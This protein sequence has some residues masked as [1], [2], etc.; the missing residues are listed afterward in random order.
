MKNMQTQADKDKK[1]ELQVQITR[2][3]T[4]TQALNT[5]LRAWKEY[6]EGTISFDEMVQIKNHTLNDASDTVKKRVILNL[7]SLGFMSK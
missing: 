1:V 5:I 2:M 3:Q 7:Q 6:T 4:S